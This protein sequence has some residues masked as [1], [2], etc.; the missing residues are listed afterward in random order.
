MI[1]ACA[2]NDKIHYTSDHFGDA[3]YFVLYEVNRESLRKLETI[4][5]T[6]PDDYEVHDHKA[7]DIL[8][9][10]K[11]KGV[12][13]IMNRAFGRNIR[14]MVRYTIPIL[15]KALSLDESLLILQDNLDVLIQEQARSDRFYVSLSNDHKALIHKL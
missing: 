4:D 14:I 8:K 10:F 9:L 6:T 11:D 3:H 2:T 5:N 15:T 1:I 7:L 13:A 12:E